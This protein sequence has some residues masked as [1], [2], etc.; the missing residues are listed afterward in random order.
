MLYARKR[1]RSTTD[2]KVKPQKLLM[3]H[4]PNTLWNN[5]IYVETSKDLFHDW[6]SEKCRQFTSKSKLHDFGEDTFGFTTVL[7]FCNTKFKSIFL[8]IT[9]EDQ[10]FSSLSKVNRDSVRQCLQF[11]PDQSVIILHAKVAQKSYG[12]EKR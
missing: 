4:C 9:R 8:C 2:S 6:I 1:S 12:S 3:S 5:Y 11:R 7:P 10:N